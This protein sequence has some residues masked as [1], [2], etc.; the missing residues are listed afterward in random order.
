M[1][2][3]RICVPNLLLSVV[4]TEGTEADKQ[5]GAQWAMGWKQPSIPSTAALHGHPV[6][7]AAPKGRGEC[8]LL[9]GR[10]PAQGITAM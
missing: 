4:C 10:A 7:A 3:P 2:T 1:E 5:P 8:A 9:C 6:Q